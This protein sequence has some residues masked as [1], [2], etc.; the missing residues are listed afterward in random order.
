MQQ[1]INENRKS[2]TKEDA[3]TINEDSTV[4]N[5]ATNTPS[6]TLEE[7]NEG[8]MK[9]S[10]L[11]V[12]AQVALLGCEGAG[13]TCL[14]D[15]LLD[16]NFHDTPP[17]EGVDEMEISIK[18]TVNWH[19]LSDDEKLR[20]L[21]KQALLETEYYLLKDEPEQSLP[22][23]TAEVTAHASMPVNSSTSKHKCVALPVEKTSLE[24]QHLPSDKHMKLV[25]IEE[26]HQLKAM[27]EK[28]DPHKRYVHLK[29]FAGRQVHN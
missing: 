16:N 27:K 20:E 2:K 19:F 5:E 15:T 1:K 29:D 28:Y 9:S 6:L 18:T 7:V 10:L 21:E 26:F 12:D 14:I 17:T 8:Y 24:D 13:K 11:P 3:D 4:A 25:S 22:S 23:I